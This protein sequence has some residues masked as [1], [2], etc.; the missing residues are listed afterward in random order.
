VV[1]VEPEPRLLRL[2][3][4]ASTPLNHAYGTNGILTALRLQLQLGCLPSG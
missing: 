4:A 2:D 3:A 1:T